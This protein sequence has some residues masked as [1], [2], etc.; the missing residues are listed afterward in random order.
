M[1]Y[2]VSVKIRSDKDEE[3]PPYVYERTTFVRLSEF[4]RDAV[5]DLIA[6][7]REDYRATYPHQ[8]GRPNFDLIPPIKVTVLAVD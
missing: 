3:H 7:A 2:Q 5:N 8:Q 6:E 1:K 4:S